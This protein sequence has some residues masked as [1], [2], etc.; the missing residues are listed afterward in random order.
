MFKYVYDTSYRNILLVNMYTQKM[1]Q[2]ESIEAIQC[3]AIVEKKNVWA[4]KEIF[5]Q[6]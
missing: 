5:L 4:T 1:Q 2:Q 6:V 3:I